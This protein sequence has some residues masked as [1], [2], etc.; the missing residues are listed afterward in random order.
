MKGALQKVYFVILIFVV[1]G[2]TLNSCKKNN[3]DPDNQT[4]DPYNPYI[5]DDYSNI[6]S[7]T[8]S[9][10]W[11][12]F[13]LHD[14]TII[15]AGEYYY[16]FSTDVA[17]GP[18]GKC[19][20]MY[21]KSK[22]LVH[23]TFLGWVFNGVP[24]IPLSFMQA[25][26]ADYQPLSLWAPF[27]IKVGDIY[28]LYYSV[29]GNNN[30]KLA[31]IALAISN[32]PEGPWADNGIVISCFP[33]DNYNAIDPAVVID[34][35]NGRHWMTY[36]SYSAGIFIVE[37]D[38][39][40]GKILNDGDKG[41][42]VA[43]RNNY[44][45]AIEGSEILYNPE[46]RKYYLFVSYDWLEDNYNVRVGR[47]DKPEGPYL[48]INGNDMASPG[49]N[50]PMITAR[51]KFNYHSGWQ[52]FGHC[53]ILNDDKKYY[54]VSQ[55]R[56]GSNKYLMD[57]HVH[58]LV[59]SET[60]WPTISPQRYVNVPQTNITSADIVGKWEHIELVNTTTFNEY[61]SIDLAANGIIS[62]LSNSSWSYE[63]KILTLS[64]RNG[65]DILKCHVF[66][67]WDWEKKRRTII[68]TGM[69]NDG[70]NCWGKKTN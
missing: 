55:A 9:S 5:A 28:R 60:G 16:I 23:W 62:G 67:E 6:A 68:Y 3:N 45:D 40:T 61:I 31:C 35:D 36:G 1:S 24:P 43:F 49:D 51:Y 4:I 64:L 37:L 47:A 44:N 12:S 57:L 17:Y 56:L 20:I 50:F 63:N 14:P 69:T 15:K 38:P 26:Q 10:L 30:L 46:L 13:N 25:N 19:G 33:S 32:S 58:R 8:N 48:D 29:P 7:Q 22:D 21:R 34:N 65:T 59:W 53:G 18:N 52:G 42:L 11:G 27:A 70:K 39:L 41:K 2:I 54:Y 66:N